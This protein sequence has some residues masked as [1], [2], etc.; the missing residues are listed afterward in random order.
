MTEVRLYGRRP[1]DY[2]HVA[3][4]VGAGRLLAEAALAE[5]KHVQFRPPWLF[6][7]GFV[8]EW[9]VLRVDAEPIATADQ[10]YHPDLVVVEDERLPAEVDVTA[11][12]KANGV[13][14]LNAAGPPPPRMAGRAMTLDLSA[15]AG[16]HRV[17][18]SVPL[19]GAAAA[20]GGVVGLEALREAARGRYGKGAGAAL[21]AAARLVHGV[22]PSG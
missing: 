6:L 3:P 14:L 4:F 13:I 18:L 20:S 21:G 12:L 7:R 10:D 11:G 1:P 8:P 17:D 15:L 9:A 5:G 19:A 2:A 16:R 22:R